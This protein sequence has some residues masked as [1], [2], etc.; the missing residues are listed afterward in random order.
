LPIYS[1]F[2]I[3]SQILKKVKGIKVMICEAIKYFLSPSSFEKIVNESNE[4]TAN[5]KLNLIKKA[6]QITE[7]ATTIFSILIP[8]LF[9]LT[10]LYLG[11]DPDFMPIIMLFGSF[12]TIGTLAKI[13]Q[14]VQQKVSQLNFYVLNKKFENCIQMLETRFENFMAKLDR[15]MGRLLP[16]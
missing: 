15:R 3:I 4:K 16:A 12:I 6:A 7:I 13:N 1:F 14:T 9:Y 10:G 11:L 2:G 8:A 5:D